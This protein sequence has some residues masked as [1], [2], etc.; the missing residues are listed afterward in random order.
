MIWLEMV[1][2]FYIAF[3]YQNKALLIVVRIIFSSKDLSCCCQTTKLFEFFYM[4]FL[5]FIQDYQ[6]LSYDQS[7]FYSFTI[8]F[9]LGCVT[10]SLSVSGCLRLIS[11]HQNREVQLFGCEDDVAILKIRFLTVFISAFIHGIPVLCFDT[12]SGL[13]TLLHEKE[14]K[15]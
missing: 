14:T 5:L 7:A 13:L 15:C 6:T 4:A 1:N 12:H 11:I 3:S 10:I 8:I 9:L 2:S